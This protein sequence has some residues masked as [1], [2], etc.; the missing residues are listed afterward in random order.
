MRRRPVRAFL[1]MV[2]VFA[3][4]SM[5]P[6][7]AAMALPM[8]M[9]GTMPNTMPGTMQAAG[10]ETAV[11]VHSE[12]QAAVVVSLRDVTDRH[13]HAPCRCDGYCGLCGAC[14]SVLPPMSTFVFAA[15]GLSFA[16]LQLSNLT[17]IP[18]SP[19]PRPPRA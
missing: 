15:A 8:E 4:L 14:F 13:Q 17:D 1:S 7:Q 11:A 2:L 12:H 5:L 10:H 16:E 19:D 18:S 9:S 3:L 6:L